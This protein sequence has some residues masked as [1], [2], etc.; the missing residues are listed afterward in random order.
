MKASLLEGYFKIKQGV[1][2][3]SKTNLTVELQTQLSLSST[4]IPN[5]N[6]KQNSP[7]KPIGDE[8]MIWMSRTT[9]HLVVSN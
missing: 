2:T 4:L 9:I 7:M 5:P 8:L 6:S 3:I 1:D